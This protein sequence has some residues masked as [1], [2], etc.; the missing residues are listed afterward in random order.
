[1]LSAGLNGTGFEEAIFLERVLG[2]IASHDP[3]VPLYIYYPMH[4][5]HSPLCVPEGY[6]ERF[7]F[8]RDREIHDPIGDLHLD[9]PNFFGP[10]DTEATAF[11]HGGSPHPDVGVFRGDDDVAATQERGVSREATT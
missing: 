3:K 8:I 2:I 5:V 9:R 1:M 4:L 10:K 6:L 7:D 11:D